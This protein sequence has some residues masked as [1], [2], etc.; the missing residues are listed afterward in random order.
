MFSKE[1][2]LAMLQDGVTPE[3]IAESMT[4]EL[5]AAIQENEAA[6]AANAKEES[7]NNLAEAILR[8]ISE[9]VKLTEPEAITD[10]LDNL[11]VADVREVLDDSIK[12]AK[13]L[14]ESGLLNLFNQPLPVPFRA[15][16][17]KVKEEEKAKPIQKSDD[18]EFAA[19]FDLFGLR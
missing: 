10:E 3:E 14:K 1:D 18:E 8:A 9:Y 17:P 7:L 11:T 15:S 13:S 16:M 6:V 5:N 19:F 12:V 4:K 2:F